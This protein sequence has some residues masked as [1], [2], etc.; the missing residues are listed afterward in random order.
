MTVESLKE[1][2]VKLPEEERHSLTLWLNGLDSD[3]WDREMAEDFS[4]GGRGAHLLE[5][6]KADIAAGK[7]RP[8]EELCADRQSKRE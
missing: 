1:A 6:V 7:F 4:P 2:I 5:K 8:V 3:E